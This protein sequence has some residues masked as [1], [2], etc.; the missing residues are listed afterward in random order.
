[1][2][3]SPEGSRQDIQ[4]ALGWL[5]HYIQ[6][7]RDSGFAKRDEFRDGAKVEA[8]TSIIRPSILGELAQHIAD[9]IIQ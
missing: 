4:Y 7:H 8:E 1:M 6:L 2:S 5:Q 9:Y 3:V